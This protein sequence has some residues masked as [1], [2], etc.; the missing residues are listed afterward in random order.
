MG[1]LGGF[2]GPYAVGYLSSTDPKI[3]FLYGLLFLVVS[4]LIGAVLSQLVRKPK[5]QIQAKVSTAD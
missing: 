3:G 2:L 5:P 4:L 1:N